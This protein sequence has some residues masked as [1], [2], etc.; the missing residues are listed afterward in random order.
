MSETPALPGIL[1]AN[2]W[3]YST[4]TKAGHWHGDG[5]QEYAL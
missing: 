4:L 5:F 2:L 1:S 3:V